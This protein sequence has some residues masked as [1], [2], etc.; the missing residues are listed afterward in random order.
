M[1]DL[2]VDET[3]EDGGEVRLVSA[4]AVGTARLI[5]DGIDGTSV[6]LAV[7]NTQERAELYVARPEAGKEYSL[8]W[9]MEAPS[10]SN[11]TAGTII[12]Q[13]F[14]V[15]GQVVGGQRQ[16]ATDGSLRGQPPGPYLRV[17][18]DGKMNFKIFTI[19]PDEPTVTIDG[20]EYTNMTYET[21][22]AGDFVEG[23][24]YDFRV[25]FRPD[26]Q[27]GFVDMYVDGELVGEFVGP[28]TPPDEV[29]EG[30][31]VSRAGIYVG[32]PGKG[33]RKL[34]VD[35]V[36]FYE[37]LPP[38]PDGSAAPA[39]EPDSAPE[40][41]PEPTPEPEPAPEESGA[42]NARVSDFDVD[43]G[44][45]STFDTYE[46]QFGGGVI[47]LSTNEDFEDAVFA[48]EHDG[49]GGTDAVL[50]GADLVF[51]TER[52]AQDRIVESVR[53]EGIVGDDSLSREDLITQGVDTAE[54]LF[55]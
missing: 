55:A 43:G 52:D 44:G 13:M 12:S 10:D 18:D 9:R 39:P 19:D 42:D 26:D 29:V 35:D 11:L 53:F 38:A 50:D 37:G 7:D 40:P 30:F 33:D 2:I 5:E 54:L 1:A 14:P 31:F 28:T 8:Q 24:T 15:E 16:W 47:T 34:L 23:R 48:F 49:A 21:Y 45:E 46:L 20:R 6:E 32:D 4:G 22:A 27:D 36:E 17:D 3:F 41:Q 51:V 25:D